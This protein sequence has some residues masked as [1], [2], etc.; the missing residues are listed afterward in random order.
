MYIQ[1]MNTAI[2]MPVDIL[3]PNAGLQAKQEQCQTATYA[4]GPCIRESIGLKNVSK[5]K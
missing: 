2:T 1:D 3:S 4:W 5:K